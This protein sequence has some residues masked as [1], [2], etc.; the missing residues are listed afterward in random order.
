MKRTIAILLALLV[1]LTATVCANAEGTEKTDNST[2]D[3]SFEAK[4]TVKKEEENKDREVTKDSGPSMGDLIRFIPITIDV[5]YNEVTVEGFFVNMNDVSISNFREFEMDVYRNNQ[6]LISGYFGDIN[7]FTVYPG[8]TQYQG[9]TFRG[10]HN[11]N[12]G[13]YVCDD[14]CYAVPVFRFSY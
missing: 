10:S 14:F 9:F 11:L 4:A 12:N 8:R 6:L 7:N 3:I 13:F 1:I 5:S 2:S